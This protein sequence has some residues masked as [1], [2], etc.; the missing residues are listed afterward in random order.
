MQHLYRKDS[1]SP[2]FL[3]GAD[4]KLYRALVSSF[5]ASLRPVILKYRNDYEGPDLCVAIPLDHDLGEYDSDIG[6]GRMMTLIRRLGAGPR[7][8]TIMI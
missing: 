1:I 2:E 6:S 4:A 7:K 5:D 8:E 3:N